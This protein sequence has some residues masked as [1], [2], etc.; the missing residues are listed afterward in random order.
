MLV[1][2]REE[3]EEVLIGN[4]IRVHA[5]L[6][7]CNNCPRRFRTAGELPEKEVISYA[8]TYGLSRFPLVQPK[9]LAGIEINPYAQQL[10]QVV[11]WIG[12]LQWMHHNGFKAP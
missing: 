7:F 2:S 9:Q 12:Y 5:C 8:S 10:A 11:I 6:T 4:N 1:L 3:G